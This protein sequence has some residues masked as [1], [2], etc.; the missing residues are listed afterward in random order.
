MEIF[1][2]FVLYGLMVVQVSADTIY[3]GIPLQHCRLQVAAAKMRLENP[4]L[5][6]RTIDIEQVFADIWR[7]ASVLPKSPGPINNFSPVSPGFLLQVWAPCDILTMVP[8]GTK[9]GFVLWK[10]RSVSQS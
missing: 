5:P 9:Q 1:R 2:S 7:F 4:G 8:D 3:W 10:L 6:R